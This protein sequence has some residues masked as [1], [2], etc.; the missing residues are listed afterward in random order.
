MFLTVRMWVLGGTVQGL[1][2]DIVKGDAIQVLRNSNCLTKHLLK[3][4]RIC[5]RYAIIQSQ[6]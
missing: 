1:Y 2:E 3:S 5:F 4:N 6:C